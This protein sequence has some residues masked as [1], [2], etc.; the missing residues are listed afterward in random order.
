VSFALN[1]SAEANGNPEIITFMEDYYAAYQ[2]ARLGSPTLN[3]YDLL[4]LYTADAVMYVH[5]N[6]V[7]GTEYDES[8][9]YAKPPNC[10]L[11]GISYGKEILSDIITPFVGSFPGMI[12]DIK[13]QTFSPEGENVWKAWLF[14]DYKVSGAIEGNYIVNFP[15]VSIFTVDLNQ[16]RKD[17][18][19]G[20]IMEG[21]LIYDNYKFLQ[22]MGRVP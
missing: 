5:P 8:P 14:Y 6:F 4:D 15:G 16:R 22:Q 2:N 21:H 13:Q 10:D 3:E 18:K 12:H 19:R 20:K 9:Y 1:S 17:G 7:Y 11:P